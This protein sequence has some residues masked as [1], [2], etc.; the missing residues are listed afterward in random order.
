MSDCIIMHHMIIEDEFYAH[1]SI[2]DLNVM[3][4]SEINM[5]ADKT[6]QFQW[7]HVPKVEVIVDIKYKNFN[8]SLLAI[9]RL[10]IKKFIIHFKMY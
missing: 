3:F 4:V 6:K 1:G 8:G 10:K 2:V 7:F 5:I 9:N